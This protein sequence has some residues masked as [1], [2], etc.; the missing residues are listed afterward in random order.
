MKY[1][2]LFCVLLT[3]TPPV[4]AQKPAGP[5][6]HVRCELLFGANMEPPTPLTLLMCKVEE[7]TAKPDKYPMAVVTALFNF[8]AE[9]EHVTYSY[10]RE[11]KEVR[12]LRG[13]SGYEVELGALSRKP[14]RD[15]KHRVAVHGQFTALK[16]IHRGL[17][18]SAVGIKHPETIP[19]LNKLQDFASASDWGG[20]K[21]SP[22][23][24]SALKRRPSPLAVPKPGQPVAVH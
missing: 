16:R 12:I 21:G 8:K 11:G 13:Q 24:V 17:L 3:L 18:G 9:I 6:Y 1:L 10:L 4:L 23:W 7:R 5:K 19:A 14:V 15:P 2:L 22:E 20:D